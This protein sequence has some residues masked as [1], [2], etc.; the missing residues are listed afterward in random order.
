MKHVNP[1]PQ[2]KNKTRK[3]GVKAI[4]RKVPVSAPV[5]LIP[6]T[7]PKTV[8]TPANPLVQ[9]IGPKEPAPG[10][11]RPNTSERTVPLTPFLYDGSLFYHF[12]TTNLR[13][14][15]FFGQET[16]IHFVAQETS[17]IRKLFIFY[18]KRSKSAIKFR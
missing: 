6:G 7:S 13:I 3:N 2:Q 12:F 15:Y 14:W 16:Y 10:R 18:E 5:G 8:S 9:R 17:I 1:W 4:S 11:T